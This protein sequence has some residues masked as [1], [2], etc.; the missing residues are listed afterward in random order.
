MKTAEAYFSHHSAWSQLLTPIRNI[1]L[2]LGM[3]E[4]IKWGSPVYTVDG[5]NVAGIMAFKSHAGIWFFQGAL[6]EDKRKLLINA[7]DGKTKA[8]R[9]LRFHSL[10][11]LDEKIVIQYL[12]EAIQNQKEG[13][14]IKPTKKGPVQ[15]HPE[16]K[17]FLVERPEIERCYQELTEFKQREY[18][19]FIAEAKKITTIKNRLEKIG[20]MILDKKGLNDQYRS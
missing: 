17:K 18:A 9:H 16:M 19:E 1:A 13:K 12:E 3:T 8:M 6:L 14:T 7:Q 20:P 5:K 15:L 10:D 2:S 4:T 11:E